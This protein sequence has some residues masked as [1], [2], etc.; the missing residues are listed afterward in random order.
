VAVAL[1]YRSAATSRK[2]RRL[3]EE[4][5]GA[6][7]DVL[8]PTTEK[9]EEKEA[10]D[11]TDAQSKRQR[12]DGDAA[13]VPSPPHHSRASP[14]F[15]VPAAVVSHHLLPFYHLPRLMDMRRL[16]RPLR[17]LCEAEAVRSV[18]DTFHS[19]QRAEKEMAASAS[20]PYC[21][22]GS[23]P[24]QPRSYDLSDAAWFSRRFWLFALCP[25]HE[26]DD[27]EA[28]SLD[29]PLSSLP[30]EGRVAT[31][32]FHSAGSW[33]GRFRSVFISAGG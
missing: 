18:N 10:E 19:L 7:H 1:F 5:G 24:C 21:V 30:L 25:Q 27:G 4:G 12:L 11:V 32:F 2:S 13:A 23:R 33:G 6:G 20:Y 8:D 17:P 16:C 22:I 9:R 14:L 28:H 3:R 31:A 29:A 15:T 26:D